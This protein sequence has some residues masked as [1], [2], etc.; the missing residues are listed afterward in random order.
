MKKIIIATSILIGF[1]ATAQEVKRC[2]TVE[3]MNYRESLQPGYI[4]STV[5]AFNNAKKANSAKSDETYIIPVVVHI[6]YNSAAQ[7]IPDSVIYNQIQILNEDFNRLNAD[8]INMRA[9]FQPH[10]GSG[11]VEFRLASFD[12]NGNPTSGITRTQ[13]THSTFMTDIIAM[14]SGDMSQLERVKSTTNGG[15]NPWNQSRYLNIWICNMAMTLLGSEVPMLMG[16]ATPPDGLSNWPAGSTAGLSDGVVLQYQAVGRN[17]PNPLVIQGQSFVVK[18]RT[19]THEVGHYLGLRHIWGDGDCSQDDG[20]A[21]TPNA[22][23]QSDQDC[24]TTKNTCVDNIG[25]VDLPDMVENFMDYSAEDC[26]NSYTKEQ[27]NLIRAVLENERWDLINDNSALGIGSKE[28]TKVSLHPN[29]ANSSV[30]LRSKEQ[31]SGS[32]TI[33]DLN[34]KV[35]KQVKANGLET[36]VDIEELPNGIYQLSVNNSVMK[37]VK[38]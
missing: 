31:L 28:I 35:V 8:T 27:I 5:D 7:N 32:I 34:G 23:A 1:G 29:P 6:V 19:A 9:D 4:Q 17:N 25:G 24:N 3:Y 30:T 13:T 16:Y 2:A 12:P 15:I 37:L 22:S 18:G 38:I 14:M 10:V 21:D 33:L 11:N 26:Q 20:I 36:I